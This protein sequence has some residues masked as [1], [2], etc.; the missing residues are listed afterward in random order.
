MGDDISWIAAPIAFGGFC[1]LMCLCSACQ[2]QQQEENQ[3]VVVYNP[4]VA[5]YDGTNNYNPS[6][7]NQ[8]YYGQQ[9]NYQQ[10]YYG[11]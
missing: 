4:N 7:Y 6:D 9:P 3:E 2:S 11:Q 1:F 10:P 8:P 5:G